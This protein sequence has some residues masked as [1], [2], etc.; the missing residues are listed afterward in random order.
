[1]HKTAGGCNLLQ[2]ALISLSHIHCPYVKPHKVLC[3]QQGSCA[4]GQQCSVLAV[5]MFWLV[6]NNSMQEA[7]CGYAH[8]LDSRARTAAWQ[9]CQGSWQLVALVALAD[10][11]L[12]P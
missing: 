4:N 5:A 9:V 11:A 7:H 8:R 6:C 10:V 2:G 12:R 3:I 1:M